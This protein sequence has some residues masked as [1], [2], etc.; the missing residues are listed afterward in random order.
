MIAPYYIE[1]S[2]KHPSLMFLSVDV[3]ELTVSYPRPVYFIHL[4]YI[5]VSKL[6][7]ESSTSENKS[8]DGKVQ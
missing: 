7:N 4:T 5:S 8:L 3:D 1:L 2:E 6:K